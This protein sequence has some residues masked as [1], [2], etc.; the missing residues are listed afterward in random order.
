MKRFCS[1]SLAFMILFLSSCSLGGDNM[2]MGLFDNDAQ[3][4]NDSFE[5]I[6][7]AIQGRDT[8][9]IK[10]LF[11]KKSIEETDDFDEDVLA[12][13]NF[14]QGEM[15]SYNDWGARSADEGKNDDGTGRDWKSIQ[16]TYDVETSKQK[17]RFAIK[18][19]ILDT[20]DPD[21]VGICSLYIIKAEDSDLQFAYWGDRLWTPGINV[22]QSDIQRSIDD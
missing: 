15:S 13:F 8:D 3:I 9:K 2:R 14:Y 4:A 20:A 11:S 6:I 1:L 22:I 16:S 18:T 21:N 12:L 5:K 17:Y 19:F 10:S 7:E